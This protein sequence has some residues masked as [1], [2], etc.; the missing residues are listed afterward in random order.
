G[1]L[2]IMVPE[3]IIQRRYS[4][5]AAC[6]WT[7]GICLYFLLFQ[8]Y[9]FRSKS[10][11]MNGRNWLSFVS[12]TD[13]QAMHTLK[14]CLSFNENRRPRLNELQQLSWLATA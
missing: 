12:S 9:P 13:K 7:I 3:W 11:I 14:L 8:Q 10:E 6:V 2:E 1:T 5:E 4:G